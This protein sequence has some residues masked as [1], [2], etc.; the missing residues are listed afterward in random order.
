MSNNEI[1]KDGPGQDISRFHADL[2]G[3]GQPMPD[4]K[5]ETLWVHMLRSMFT[6]GMA[7]KLGP[8]VFFIYS[9]IKAHCNLDTGNAFPSHET[10]MELTASFTS[11]TRYC[12]C[13]G[14]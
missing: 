11:S 1:P 12:I 3:A 2:I 7:K 9:A 4:L 5:V 14:M 13:F 8:T 6:K 10:L